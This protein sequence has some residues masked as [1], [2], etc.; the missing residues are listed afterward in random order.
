MA[1]LGIAKIQMEKNESPYAPFIIHTAP[2]RI[3]YARKSEKIHLLTITI[4]IFFQN[5]HKSKEVH[6]S[7]R[8]YAKLMQTRCI[9]HKMAFIYHTF[10]FQMKWKGSFLAHRHL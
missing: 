4:Q 1:L 10:Y 2:L 3:V 5:Y 9:A 6:F 7:V 8:M